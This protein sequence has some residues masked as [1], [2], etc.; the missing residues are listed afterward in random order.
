M[1]KKL[2]LFIEPQQLND[3]QYLEIDLFSDETISVVDS[4]QDVKDITKIYN[5]FSRGFSIPASDRNNLIF[6]NYYNNFL[7]SHDARFK[8][9]AIIK[10]SGADYR[11]GFI[12]T[13]GIKLTS[14]DKPEYYKLTFSEVGVTL[15]D[16]LDDDKLEELDYT[17]FY[18]HENSI[19]SVVQ[20]IRDGLYKEGI[21]EEL[22]VDGYALYP[23]II[24]PPIFTAG[25]AVPAPYNTV[26][27]MPT[28]NDYDFYLAFY[29]LE[30]KPEGDGI[31]VYNETTEYILTYTC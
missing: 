15:K 19:S 17:S 11:K 16:V 29:N 31:G 30:N 10:I 4:I 21:S 23:D 6:A 25:K 8:T 9:P 18:Q 28:T 3:G 12:S 13:V 22:D 14:N 26:A 20:G 24:Y 7:L 1:D 2:Q 27:T 5:M